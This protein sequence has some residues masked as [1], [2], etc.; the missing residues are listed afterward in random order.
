MNNGKHITKTKL[1]HLAVL[2]IIGQWAKWAAFAGSSVALGFAVVNSGA[3]TFLAVGLGFLLLRSLLRLV[4]RVVVTLV[5]IALLM[6]A[7]GFII[8]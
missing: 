1:S 4:F 3:G 8:L 5:Y 6:L 2:H 7:L